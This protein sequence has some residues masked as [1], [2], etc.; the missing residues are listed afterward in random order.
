MAKVFPNAPS[1]PPPES[2]NRGQAAAESV[3]LT[4]WKKSLL[5]NGDGFTVF[6]A[7]G[8][9]VYR[10]DNYITGKKGEI[11]L[12]DA[13]G[14]PLLTIRR[15][16]LSLE[17]T[18]LVFDGE[19][20]DL[21]RFTARKTLKLLNSNCL[22]EVTFFDGGGRRMNEPR[23]KVEGSYERRRCAVYDEKRRRVAEIKPKEAS[24]RGVSIGTEIFHLAVTA[25]METASAMAIVILLDQ[26]FEPLPSRRLLL[27]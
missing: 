16:R 14:S 26:M 24:V 19:S 6:N 27:N 2:C 15:K 11:I 8:D 23:F 5:F 13:L 20:A 1:A 4:V 18:W 12:M 21:R 25:E 10:V 7:A 17:D 3:L 22:A 9:L